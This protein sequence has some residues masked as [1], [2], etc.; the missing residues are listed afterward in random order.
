MRI[1]SKLPILPI[2]ILISCT[3]SPMFM[4]SYNVRLN[5]E[6]PDDP[7]VE[8]ASSA[9]VTVRAPD[10][11]SAI[12][13]T[14]SINEPGLMVLS[15]DLNVKPGPDREFRISLM[16][17]GGGTAFT[18]L[19]VETIPENRASAV[20]LVINQAGFSSASSVLI[21]RDQYP[22]DSRALDSTLISHGLTTG[23]GDGQYSVYPS[24]EMLYA[25]LRPGIDL[26]IIS[27]DQ[28]QEFYDNYAA[29]AHRFEQ[30][31]YDGGTILWCA[32]DMGW[33]YGSISDAGLELPGPVG[34]SYSLDIYNLVTNPGFEL[35]GGLPDT[36]R[37]NYASQETFFNLPGGCLTYLTNTNGSPTLVGFAAG[38][39]WIVI[40]GQALEYNYD[41]RDNYSIGELLPR[42]IRFL[43]GIRTGEP[44]SLLPG[45]GTLVSEAGSE[46]NSYLLTSEGTSR[47]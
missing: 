38:D 11:G 39:G 35:I 21:F 40:S 43:L 6:F 27:N 8:S 5:C 13:S 28:P 41:R 10:I 31:A 23:T 44:L 30:F 47:Q 32:C 17:D 19:A 26:V 7:L 4:P 14:F 29:S 22:W 33:N 37:G 25:E 36:L 45:S 46:G 12:D 2:L 15:L 24:S 9:R 34:I 1:L 3:E 18:G 42:L 16:N 20:N